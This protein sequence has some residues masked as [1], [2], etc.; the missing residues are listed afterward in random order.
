MALPF[1][2]PNFN[3]ILPGFGQPLA[4][5]R[6]RAVEG[7]PVGPPEPTY[8]DL[9]PVQKAWVD[10]Q[11]ALQAKP[12]SALG[13]VSAAVGRGLVVGLPRMVGQALQAS[14][15][16]DDARYAIGTKLVAGAR[17]RE[18]GWA[19][20]ET[21]DAH[22][23]IT[24]AFTSAG[25]M[26][27]PSLAALPVMAGASALGAPAALAV[28]IG[29]AAGGALFG[30][31][32]YQDTYERAIKAGKTPE[33]AHTLG[34]KTGTTE[35]VGETI[36]G[37]MLGKVLTKTGRVLTSQKS[38]IPTALAGLREPKYLKQLAKEVGENMLV[39]TAT[40]MGQGA[41]QAGVEKEAGISDV[42]P[43]D[44]ATQ[45]IGP[46]LALTAL[47]GPLGAASLRAQQQQ[48]K[49]LIAIVEDPASTTSDVY[50]ATRA[51]QPQLE[52]T[53]GKMETLQWRLDA[54]ASTAKSPEEQ[55]YAAEQAALRRAQEAGIHDFNA[56]TPRP[57]F[58][59]T[60]SGEVAAAPETIPYERV[61]G[62]S[63]GRQQE[64]DLFGLTGN[65][66]TPESVE[67]IPYEKVEVGTQPSGQM[68]LDFDQ[69]YERRGGVKA[70]TVAPEE[71]ETRLRAAQAEE[72]P[73]QG[74][75][76]N[77]GLL[78]ESPIVVEGGAQ[79]SI[80]KQ[81]RQQWLKQR[82]PTLSQ[83]MRSAM[84]S[85]SPNELA[86]A[87]REVWHAKGGE[88]GKQ[89]Y[90]PQIEAAYAELTKKDI[91]ETRTV[92][93]GDRTRP[94][95]DLAAPTAIDAERQADLTADAQR[96]AGGR[97]TAQEKAKLTRT[98]GDLFAPPK[99]LTKQQQAAQSSA[100]MSNAAKMAARIAK[101][102]DDGQTAAV[103]TQG[104]GNAQAG[105]DA[106]R[107]EGQGQAALLTDATVASAVAPPVAQAPSQRQGDIQPDTKQRTQR[108]ARKKAQALAAQGQAKVTTNAAPPSG[109]A[110]T[111]PPPVTTTPSVG[112]APV[113]EVIVSSTGVEKARPVKWGE[114]STTAPAGDVSYEAPALKRTQRTVQ[115]EARLRAGE[116]R[117]TPAPYRAEIDPSERRDV[118]PEKLFGFEILNYDPNRARG[119][120]VNTHWANEYMRAAKLSLQKTADGQPTPAARNAQAALKWL[121]EYEGVDIIER[122][123]LRSVEGIM[124]INERFRELARE[125]A[126][127]IAEQIRYEMEA[128]VEERRQRI[129]QGM[130]VKDA[131][132]L[133]YQ[134]L[135]R[136]NNALAK[137]ELKERKRNV[138]KI[139][140]NQEKSKAKVQR[141][142]LARQYMEYLQQLTDAVV[143]N[144]PKFQDMHAELPN[145]T[146][147]PELLRATESGRLDRVL[148]A[149]EL[150]GPSERIKAVAGTLRRLG[151][152]TSVRVINR[153]ARD[154]DGQR[155]YARYDHSSNTVNVYLGGA[156]PHTLVHEVAHAATVGRI[157][158]AKA[159][160]KKLPALR[161]ADEQAAVESLVALRD[162]MAE[163]KKSDTQNR[164]A[165]KSEEEFVAEVMSNEKFQE[166]LHQKPY[167]H[168]SLM[169]KFIDW[170]SEFFGAQPYEMNALQRAVDITKTFV[171][172]SRFAAAEGLSFNHS[173][174]G[175]MAQADAAGATLTRLWDSI[176]AKSNALGSA[177]PALRR[178][179][180]FA[181]SLFNMAQFIE[182][183]PAL[184][185]LADG[186]RQYMEANGL[187]TTLRQQKQLEFSTVTTAL[188][189]AFGKYSSALA[190]SW[191]E[192]LMGFAGD[193]TTLGIDLNKDFDAN[194]QA[195]P[196]LDVANKDY[197]NRRHAEYK[198]IPDA[199][200]KPLEASFRLFRKNYIQHTSLVLRD[201]L[202]MYAKD[203]PKLQA[204]V[205][206]LD[207]RSAALSEGTNPR[208]EYYHD[209][210]SY[211][212]DQLVRKV[213]KD[214]KEVDVG[215]SH[216]TA[217][218]REIEKFY[219]LA[220][221]NPYM[222]LGRS[223]DYF[224]EFSV[225]DKEGAWGAVQAA[226]AG[227]G[228]VVGQPTERRHI[229]LRF[230]NPAQRD[231]IVKKL[232]ALGDTIQPTTLRKGS[233]FNSEALN[234]MQG[235]PQ[236]VHDL[237]KKV[238]ED[239]KGEEAAMMR[240]YLKRAYLDALPDSSAQKALAQRKDSGV[241]GYDADFLRNYSK[242]AEGM[243]SMISNAYTMPMYDSAFKAMKEEVGKV[244][245]T[246]DVDASSADMANEVMT[247]ISRR[248]TNSIDPVES[249]V[250]DTAKA[251]GFNF[252]LA[253]SPAF[254][255]TNLMQPYH[256]TLPMLGGR[257]GFTT[258]AREMAR[259]TAKGYKLI[260][261]AAATGWT[262][263]MD[264]GG[265]Y[266]ALMGVLDLSLP[267]DL[268]GLTKGEREFL[269]RLIESGQLDTT[270]GHELARM[271]SGEASVRGTVT[272]VMSVGSHYTEVLNRLTAGL[273]AY[274]LSMRKDTLQNEANKQ[275]YATNRAIEMVR[276]TQY[277][278]S[279]NNTARALGRHGVLGKVTPLLASFQQ[280]SFQTMELLVRT[281][282]DS[283]VA[284]QNLSP[285]MQVAAKREARKALAGIFGTSAILAGTLGLPLANVIARV[286]DSALSD[287]DDPMDVKSAY[288]E[289]LAGVFGK[290]VAEA[291]ARGVPRALFGFDTAG[292]M[293][294]QD[295]MPGTRFFAD[296]RALKDKIES[297]AFNMLGPAVSAG[298]GV[299]VGAN[300][301]IDGQVMDGLIEMMPLALKGPLKAVK[302][303]D[304][305]FT[306]S[307]GNK[308]PL[309]VTTWDS[310]VQ[311]AGFTP[312]KKA[313][314]SEVNFA[315]RQRDMLLKQRKAR[316]SNEFY[317]AQEAGQDTTALVQ[318]IM[319]F[320]NQNPQYRIDLAAGLAARAKAR[321][322]AAMTDS[323]IATLP[324]YLPTLDRYSYANTR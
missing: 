274:N 151:L 257:Y 304:V 290:D 49:K 185:P 278:Y 284:D 56:E 52:A 317:R 130:G 318:E 183:I 92:E 97:L 191:N 95:L 113:E 91:R 224:I 75:A 170:L 134:E 307:T 298:T 322:T 129:A 169:R 106:V 154:A 229:F 211:N 271:A 187:K 176:S 63:D 294:M 79:Y 242:R 277:D 245:R 291:V 305:G 61:T 244:E 57:A 301:V 173:A 177:L 320:G 164:Y 241:P 238:D 258:A 251:F 297:G 228:K 178:T 58:E 23:A 246:R 163:T 64:L 209:A 83:G 231:A 44:A 200:K 180:W 132:Q 10:K 155:V 68:P 247:E 230:E 120:N 184:R 15:T 127:E 27:A 112:A 212:L 32:T 19:R 136:I 71:V 69:R 313:E 213:M 232:N 158:F 94:V 214:A 289:W 12:R 161:T 29:S 261:A 47:L 218:L 2:L 198:Q 40:E 223:G 182:R 74:T 45:A 25:E 43:W 259:S 1:D 121:D 22:G 41:V 281:S 33:E 283:V 70:Q 39:Q 5:P 312:S 275:E 156:N 48:N 137:E 77:L 174:T 104:Q 201:T 131:D 208:P 90:L 263:G 76:R 199:L 24:N 203:S 219:H 157:R 196:E 253:F 175:A 96:V 309:E 282:I 165:F 72:R 162:L 3:S 119:I 310:L 50:R 189:M 143:N 190:R 98:Q 293:G 279:D 268:G 249:P 133:T 146:V 148:M 142:A 237:M 16:P 194:K 272:K 260:K 295:I 153:V 321:A 239:F 215:K 226:L 54:L 51:L 9:D 205:S 36:G 4:I 300:K 111:T 141:E 42:T 107:T 306:T 109:V 267:A 166:W 252:F 233:L 319:E 197:I 308:L 266:G 34:L 299:L 256:L 73:A 145:Y 81:E 234:N 273:A 240:Q 116:E 87:L 86:D 78:R 255:L 88:A 265:F 80:T 126:E 28:G 13:E 101:E 160:E 135:T 110:A 195:N 115:E 311:A 193:M 140:T 14:G 82:I 65:V 225:A 168:R 108:G 122:A 18:P 124:S 114:F 179:A 139:K 186:I 30:G 262:Q 152:D 17:E 37:A 276:S 181:S 206:M 270:Q 150:D 62:V 250:L 35:F 105:Q 315:F 138:Y 123:V 67:S 285:E 227:N 11:L 8:D 221:S 167:D 188:R 99:P 207:M 269:Q 171:G 21:P 216:L 46:S 316:L 302:M 60:P 103:P 93:S 84:L 26:V 118:E 248:F 296:R 100:R 55:K 66:V 192:K 288:R 235:V 159:A 149:L 144:D 210:Y 323:D 314:Q 85:L 7:E 38:D 280:Y 31:A 128:I 172:K 117:F 59:L 147:T 204:L 20:D 292:R 286:L 202:A 324:R 220:V 243:A 264:V 287:D 125:R 53:A 89:L 236:F 6:Q 222:H 217:S 254:W 102:L 303:E